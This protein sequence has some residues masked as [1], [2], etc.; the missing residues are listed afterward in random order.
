MIS[1]LPKWIEYGAF[2]LAFV[3]GCINAIGLLGFDH[4]SVSHLSGTAT[5]LGTSFLDGPIQSSLNFAG[6]LFAFFVGS[7]ISGFLLPGATLKLGRHYDTALVVES[8]LIFVALY[9]LSKGSFYG[10]YAASAACGIQ[11]AL[12][13]TYS[14]AVVRTTHLT[15]IFTDLGVMFGSVLRGEAF[16]KRKAILFTLIIAGFVIGGF[17]GAYLFGQ[18]YFQALLV[19]GIICLALA[20]C[21]R[22][23]SIQYARKAGLP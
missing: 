15:G 2:I 23:Y 13:T 21:Y 22:G 6:V 20:A 7:A 14:G 10:H 19:P 9:L 3:A 16:D 17:F 11:N 1:K 12:A 18:F 8:L 4:Q 5:L